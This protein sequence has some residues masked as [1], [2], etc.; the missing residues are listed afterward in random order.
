MATSTDNYELASNIR[1][2][3]G[4]VRSWIRTYIWFEG[5]AVAL[6]W[7]GATFW[8]AI[9]ADYLFVLLGA[10]ELPWQA[11]AVLLVGIAGVLAFIL[12]WWIIR[13]AFVS[14]QDHSMAV[15]LERRYGIFRDSLLTSVEMS[16]RPD[17]A[18]QFNQEML[19]HTRED[20]GKTAST[21][22]VGDIFNMTP[23]VVSSLLAILLGAGIGAFAY[24]FPAMF[25]LGASRLYLLNDEP[26]P[27]Y[28]HI[29]VVG[30]EIQAASNS[31]D[32]DGAT[33]RVQIPFRDGVVKVAK[34][35]DIT[36]RVRADA[37]RPKVPQTCDVFYYTAEGGRDRVKMQVDGGI[38]D[39]YQYFSFDG[40]P[41]RGVL[42]TIDFD[43]RGYD[44]WAHDLRVEV[45]ASPALTEVTLDTQYPSYMFP[46]KISGHRV[47]TWT[48]GKQLPIGAKL[49]VLGKSSKDL[50]QATV[51]NLTTN[52][53]FVIDVSGDD[54][55]TFTYDPGV[56]SEDLTLL[57]SLR[58]TD[59]VL[60]ESPYRIHI[61]ARE[62]LP[63]GVEARLE[64]IGSAV[65]PDVVIPF[66]G[67]IADDYEVDSSWID[68]DTA[69]GGKRVFPFKL[70]KAGAVET[71]IDFRQ[72]RES[73][74]APL[75]LTPGQRMV[76]QVKARDF[77]DLADGSHEGQGDAYELDVV[78][79][80]ELVRILERREVEIRR[81]F[82]RM[83]DD[84]IRSRDLLALMQNTAKPILRD[85]SDDEETG[86]EEQG[87]RRDVSAEIEKRKI[88][89]M[90]EALLQ[91]D[92]TG[93]EV[94]ETAAAFANIRDQLVNNR[95]DVEDQKERLQRDV[96]A[97]LR[98]INTDSV[99][100]L[101]EQLDALDK[102]LGDPDVEPAA[103]K[104][105]LEAASKVI[106]EME[107]VLAKMIE[108]EDFNQLLEIVR[109]I[110]KEQEGLIE[111]TKKQ[112]EQETLEALELLQ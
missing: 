75:T 105:S 83:L 11:R 109:N 54:L 58:D 12:Y 64:G 27:R 66:S 48:A 25:A 86:E 61:S 107:A 45:V 108:I 81:D 88:A 89:Y 44:H 97:P 60:S 69:E 92:K 17:H 14:L 78:T 47:E 68:V 35:S 80:E 65:T 6:L 99:P 21:V 31:R 30:I 43:V 28:A 72:L 96:I 10:S 104:A 82:E 77:Y 62:D 91:A 36:L 70:K 67:R 63:P 42:S 56:I 90:Q 57:I 101:K 100:A 13:R 7:L 98:K 3:L 103:A 16:E 51:Q 85:K 49:L 87:E 23:L 110:L 2:L 18:G 29:E 5:I 41:F 55:K 52:E 112:Q 9:G 39:S 8:L 93:L 15:V 32:A 73:E 34:G 40:K 94:L 46:D 95:V 111:A 76:V 22:R 71:S 4:G 84:M 38:L 79:P 59:D 24:F 53:S 37:T 102:A 26:W 19:R 20:A 1:S 33:R 74:T 50:K 106:A